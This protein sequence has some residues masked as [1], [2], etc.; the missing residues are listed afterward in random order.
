MTTIGFCSTS[1]PITAISPKRFARAKA[2]LEGK[3]VKLI[4]GSLTGKQDHYRSGSI[5]D[6]AAEVNQLIYNDEVGI[7]MA[8]IGGTNTNS[9]LPYLDY[10]YLNQHPKTV[11]GYSDAT[12]LL[13]AVQTQ[14]PNCRTLYGPAL[15]ASFGEWPPFVNE[16]WTAF[17]KI[18]NTRHGHSV[19]IKAPTYWDDE[20]INWND[21][22]RP[23]QQRP[24]QWHSI[25][26]SKLTG[27]I[28]GGN[29]NTIYGILGSNYFPKLSPNDL[30]FIEDAEKDASTVEKNFAM[31]RDAGA[32]DQVSGIILGKHALFDDSGTSR[33]PIDI[34]LE[35]L[36]GQQ[37]PIIYD[38]DSCHTVPMITTPLGAQTTINAD[39]GTITFSRF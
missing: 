1:T 23:K 19:T 33:K 27:R 13:L 36:N 2:F 31:M 20:A 8:T 10:D 38:Y 26:A 21:F 14:A 18:I 4:A 3:G 25:G 9:I 16:T 28:M 6:R 39:D 5:L 15:V 7:I 30:L 22:E 29:L 17:E 37:I 32:F 24:N 35:V 12:A 34:L 11:V